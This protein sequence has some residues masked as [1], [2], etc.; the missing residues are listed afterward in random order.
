MRTAPTFSVSAGWALRP[1]TT[2]GS[3]IGTTNTT[4]I[5]LTAG[6]KPHAVLI[7][8]SGSSGLTAGAVIGVSGNAGAYFD[9]SGEL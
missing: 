8:F 1:L 4:S 3:I 7:S 5:F 9:F 2:G 6:A